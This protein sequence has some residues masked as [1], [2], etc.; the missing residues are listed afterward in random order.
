MTL[1]AVPRPSLHAVPTPS[2]TDLERLVGRVNWEGG[3]KHWREEGKAPV[4]LPSERDKPA[5]APMSEAEHQ[6][7][8]RQRKAEREL[9]SRQAEWTRQSD[10]VKTYERHKFAARRQGRSEE[11]TAEH[12]RRYRDA[13]H[14][15]STVKNPYLP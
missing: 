6:M 13:L 15:L 10:L 11:M 7:L 8:E 2:A 1:H 14:Y 9:R 12:E 4:R 3:P 5:G